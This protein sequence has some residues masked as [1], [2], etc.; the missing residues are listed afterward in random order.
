MILQDLKSSSQRSF[1]EFVSLLSLPDD[2]ILP[3]E[4]DSSSTSIVRE[5]INPDKVITQYIH[6]DL[7][8]IFAGAIEI[9]KFDGLSFEAIKIFN[10]RLKTYATKR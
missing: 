5:K 6:Q 2:I 7:K 8:G 4:A 1:G 3:T 10:E 9:G